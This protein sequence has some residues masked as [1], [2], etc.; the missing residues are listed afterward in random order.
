MTENTLPNSVISNK[1][2]LKEKLRCLFHAIN[3]CYKVCYKAS[4]QTLFIFAVLVLTTILAITFTKMF[5]IRLVKF[6]A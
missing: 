2:P 1:N 6:P 4:P 3:V 5:I